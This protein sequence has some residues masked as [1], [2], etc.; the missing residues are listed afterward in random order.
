MN[1]ITK[2]T[3]LVSL[4]CFTF[5]S[6]SQKNKENETNPTQ[7]EMD[8]VFGHFLLV[9]SQNPSKQFKLRDIGAYTLVYQEPIKDTSLFEKIYFANGNIREIYDLSLEFDIR[10]ETIEH[11]Y[12][13]G[14]MMNTQNDYSSYYYSTHEQPRVIQLKHLQYLDYSSPTRST[15]HAI[16]VSTMILSA[17]TALVAAP[18]INMD[19][20]KGAIFSNGYLYTVKLGLIGVAVGFPISYFTRTKRYQI[21][22]DKALNDS[23]YWYLDKEQ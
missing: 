21:T 14:S 8:S 15:L 7:K 13:D 4:V 20:K 19:F 22:P 11:T 3:I 10:N 12:N 9:N 5:N 17:V 16:G 6:H 2:I 1:W 23:N 18:I